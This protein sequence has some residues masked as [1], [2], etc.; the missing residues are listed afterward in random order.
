MTEI[1]PASP[2]ARKMALLMIAITLVIGI[3]LLALAGIYQPKLEA[4]L[5]DD[6]ALMQQ[7]VNLILFVFV[8]LLAPLMFAAVYFWR[9]GSAVTR[10]GRFPPPNYAVVRD[11]PVIEGQKAIM[12]GRFI[13]IFS[14]VL[15]IGLVGIPIM[16]WQVSR[17]IFGT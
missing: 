3:V 15:G 10:A 14:I 1:Q 2:G 9:F 11:T 16:F 7:K 13:K 6:S 8:V 4:W 12:R 5:L 17:V